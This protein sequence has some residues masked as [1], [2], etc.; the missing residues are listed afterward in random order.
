M[1]YLI[2]LFDIKGLI[3]HGYCL[4]WSPILLWLHVISDLVITVAY[5][6]IPLTLIYFIRKLPKSRRLVE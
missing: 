3:P 1:Q 5:Y 6:S 4:S 2:D